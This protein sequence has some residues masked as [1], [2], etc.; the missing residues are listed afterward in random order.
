MRSHWANENSG[1]CRQYLVEHTSI[2]HHSAL[3]MNMF[4]GTLSFDSHDLLHLSGDDHLP[5]Q[6]CRQILK[7]I[8]KQ[9]LQRQY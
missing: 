8:P 4:I 5:D 1:K 3:G 6:L 9:I 2:T 7:K